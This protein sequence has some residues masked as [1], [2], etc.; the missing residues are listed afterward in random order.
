MD[1]PYRKFE[2]TRL[3]AAVET[4][5]NQLAQNQDITL[6]TTREHAVGFLCQQLVQAGL[7]GEHI[8]IDNDT[9]LV[10]LELLASREDLPAVL[11]LEAPERNA[12]WFLE[13]AL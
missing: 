3:W 8:D 11:K 7:S 5:L 4:A 2:H 6:H 10:L 12:L 9:A 13:A 1:H